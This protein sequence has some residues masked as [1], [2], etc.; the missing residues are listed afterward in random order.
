M[1]IKPY[2][3]Q[4]TILELFLKEHLASL[5]KC[6]QGLGQGIRIILILGQGNKSNSCTVV[7]L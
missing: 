4:H 7:G 2:L 6:Q 3:K 1:E 5:I